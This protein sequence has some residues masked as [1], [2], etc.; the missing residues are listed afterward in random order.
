AAPC[1]AQ[2]T[3]L[4]ESRPAP[5]L[6][7]NAP[8]ACRPA[9]VWTYRGRTLR[10][11]TLN[12]LRRYWTADGAATVQAVAHTQCFLQSWSAPPGRTATRHRAEGFPVHYH[13][14]CFQGLPAIAATGPRYGV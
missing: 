9:R 6:R 7:A 4:Q 3:P 8:I 13:F 5:A 2:T 12:R 14:V 10:P 11:A 1:R